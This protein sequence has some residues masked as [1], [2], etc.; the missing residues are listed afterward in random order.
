MKIL[1]PPNNASYSEP[2]WGPLLFRRG[3]S[4]IS[5]GPSIISKWPL[6]NLYGAV[7][8]SLRGPSR[9]SCWPLRGQWCSFCRSKTTLSL[10]KTKPT[11]PTCGSKSTLS[12]PS[13]PDPTL[14][15]VGVKV[16]S[17][18]RVN[19]TLPFSLWE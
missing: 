9:I 10:M 2:L 18:C 7:S 3:P 13:E 14:Q 6:Q 16:H 1:P 8:L 19:P 4:I 15:S 12:L 17:V 5:T 11:P